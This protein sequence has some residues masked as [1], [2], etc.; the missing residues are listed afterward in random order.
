MKIEITRDGDIRVAIANQK[1]RV[2]AARRP[3]RGFR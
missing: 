2:V 3:W 1:A